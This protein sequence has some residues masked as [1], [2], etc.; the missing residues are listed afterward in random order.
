M[1]RLA[2]IRTSRSIRGSQHR[3]GGDGRTLTIDS[4]AVIGRPSSTAAPHA[5]ALASR[6]VD[7]QRFLAE[8]VHQPRISRRRFEEFCYSATAYVFSVLIASVLAGVGAY[9]GAQWLA[10]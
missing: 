10:G 6:L 2:H 5:T 7:E 4:H 3:A 8:I 1:R 9:F